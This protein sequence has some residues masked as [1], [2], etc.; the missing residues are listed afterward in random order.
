MPSRRPQPAAFGGWARDRL[1]IVD[2][3]ADRCALLTPRQLPRW[4]RRSA[5]EQRRLPIFRAF[6][7]AGLA[8]PVD[9][10][11]CTG[12]KAWYCRRRTSFSPYL[13]GDWT[14]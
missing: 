3:A 7:G 9:R 2:H 6:V 4:R 1:D 5:A 10:R 12:R 11:H 14:R 8:R 13:E